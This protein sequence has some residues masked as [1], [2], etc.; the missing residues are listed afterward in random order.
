MMGKVRETIVWIDVEEELPDA[1]MEVLICFERSDSNQL[2]TCMATYD[3]S[4]EGESPWWVDGGV[5][6]GQVLFWAEKPSGPI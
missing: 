6:L 3:D 2:D 1:D 5:Y 4:V